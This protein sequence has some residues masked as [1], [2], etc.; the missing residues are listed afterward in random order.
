MSDKRSSTKPF[1]I[2]LNDEYIIVINKI[3]KIVVQP[4]P[5]GEKS[6]LTSL[7]KE[8]IKEKVFPCHRLD[9]ETT[10]LIIYA[11]SAL[12]Q[13]N[14]MEQFRNHIVKK[15]YIAFIKGKFPKKSGFFDSYILDKDGLR[16]GEKPK[17]ARIRYKVLNQKFEFSVVNLAPL[18]GRTNQ[19]RIQLART[20]HPILGERKY[21]FGRDFR[22]GFRRLAL[23]AYF[24]SFMH[25]FSNQKVNL[26]IDLAKDM[27]NFFAIHFRKQF[28]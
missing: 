7:L 19:L 4:T 3:T 26:E 9:K 17:R 25:L 2:V 20:G 24:I 1:D 14:I 28:L 18:T 22:I 27:E 16:F 8:K 6:T 15:R 21:A 13:K 10:G 12:I 11:K 5:R 23:H